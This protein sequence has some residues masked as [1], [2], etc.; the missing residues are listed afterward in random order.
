MDSVGT[1][2]ILIVELSG[3]GLV[4]NTKCLGGTLGESPKSQLSFTQSNSVSFGGVTS[5]NNGDVSGNHGATDVWIVKMN[6][7]TE[8]TIWYLDADNDGYYSSSRQSVTSPGAGWSISPANGGGDCNDSD[9]LIYPGAI[10]LN[11]QSS[12]S[13]I[14]RT[15]VTKDIFCPDALEIEFAFNSNS[16]YD[17]W[18]LSEPTT[19][20]LGYNGF[21]S[22]SKGQ[23]IIATVPGL[24]NSDDIYH[25]I[26]IPNNP[27][28]FTC[29]AR[30]DITGVPTNGCDATI[31]SKLLQPASA[32]GANDGVF[33]FSI[34]A[35][36]CANAPWFIL[37]KDISTNILYAANGQVND[38]KVITVGN[39]PAGTFTLS[40][41]DLASICNY[42][43]IS[44]IIVRLNVAAT[45]NSMIAKINLWVSDPWKY[46]LITKLNEALKYCIAGNIIEAKATLS[47][48]INQ[49][50]GKR[51]K[52]K[53]F[54]NAQADDLIA[55]ANAII[56]AINNGTSDCGKDR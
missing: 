18:T 5:S 15:V 13:E 41:G 43:N 29:G 36:S 51:G 47:D 40:Y 33:E 21:W 4:T 8:A 25:F 35:S 28:D 30:A 20:L 49:V 50:R 9:P 39:L 56:N 54:T 37:L 14:K 53:G 1:S 16:C 38:D 55:N 48:F 6:V 11:C 7:A 42:P 10:V 23:T 22:A 12:L 45:I 17:T 27:N 19:E 2:D 44:T 24:K 46:G 52:E 3:D 26:A 31:V 34:S 32:P